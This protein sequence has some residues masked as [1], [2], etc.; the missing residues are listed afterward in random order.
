L[1]Q[2]IRWGQLPVPDLQTGI[3]N[4]Q[5]IHQVGIILPGVTSNGEPNTQVAQYY[6]KYLPN[7]GG[8]GQLLT[9]PG[10]LENTWIK[11]REVSLNYHIPTSLF[12]KKRWVNSLLLSLIGLDLFYFY[13][14]LPD[15]IN[16][17]GQMAPAMLLVW[18]GLPFPASAH[19]VSD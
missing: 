3:K 2:T 6:N 5:Y 19:I 14:S 10:I 1:D 9:T 4:Q 18:N 8:W 15:R 13:T 7:A 17:E 12:G 11:M 16:P